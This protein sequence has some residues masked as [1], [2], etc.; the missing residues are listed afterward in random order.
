[1]GNEVCSIFFDL[2]KAFDSVPHRLLIHRLEE[3]TIDPYIV[4]WTRSYLTCRSQAV[5]VGGEQSSS[6]PV[7]SGVPQGS[8]LGPLLFLIFINEI[9][10]QIST[11]SK[12]SLFADDIAL[13]RSILS[14]MDY[15]ILQSDVSVIVSWINSALLSLQPAKCCY[16]LISRK[17]NHLPPPCITV[18]GT[19][20]ALVSSVKYLGL[21]IHSD[22]SWSPHVANLCIKARRLIGLLYRRFG[23]HADLVTLLQLYKSFIRPHLEYCSIVWNPHLIRDIEPLEKVQRFAL[24]VIFLLFLRGESSIITTVTLIPCNSETST[25]ELHNFRA[26]SFLA[27]FRFG[28][29]YLTALSP[30]THSPVSNLI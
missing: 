22:L 3:I 30:Y 1:M 14:D 24:R 13:Y 7:I 27:P 19:P 9:V 23:K 20:L 10:D 6:L 28:T 26:P 15:S 16:M 18:E 11:G 4:Q 21:Q 2:K 17:K 12:I 29:H 25:R 8:V 5:V